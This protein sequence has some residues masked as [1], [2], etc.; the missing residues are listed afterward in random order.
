MEIFDLLENVND[1][2]TFMIFVKAMLKERYEDIE[3][4]NKNP[5]DPYGSSHKGWENVTLE[6][7]FSAAIA[8]SD[9]TDFGSLQNIHDN[10]WYKFATFLYC[11]KIYE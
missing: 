5:S 3:L 7:F 9:S 1:Q 4:E 2:E 11:G 6:G 8:W 10:L